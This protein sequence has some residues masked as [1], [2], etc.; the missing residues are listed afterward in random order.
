[1]LKHRNVSL[2]CF[3][4]KWLTALHCQLCDCYWASYDIYVVVKLKVFIAVMKMIKYF[5][6]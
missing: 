5:W 3:T 6:V 2:H 4:D 1:M